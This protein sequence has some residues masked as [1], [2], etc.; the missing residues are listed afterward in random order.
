MG[1]TAAQSSQSIVQ[2]KKSGQYLTMTKPPPSPPTPARPVNDVLRYRNCIKP[3]GYDNAI[4]AVELCRSY[5][6]FNENITSSFILPS[7]SL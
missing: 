7:H 2:V 4:Y 6:S 5:C 3:A 1:T